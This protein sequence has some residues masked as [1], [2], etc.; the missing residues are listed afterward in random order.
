[1]PEIIA[2]RANLNSIEPTFENRI[3]SIES[4]LNKGFKVEVDVRFH[5]D[6]VY[7]GHDAAQE[8][9]PANFYGEQDIYFHCKDMQSLLT[10]QR[11]Y[12]G[13]NFFTHDNDEA[14]I[15]SRGML[16]IHPE[17][18]PGLYQDHTDFDFSR[19]IAVLPERKGI[20][21]NDAHLRFLGKFYGI[22]TDYPMRYKE[23]FDNV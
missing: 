4:A 2:H 7:L 14:T 13:S 15:T 23:E 3:K 8:I 5:L 12:R 9:L 21:Y 6:R 22:C 18:L 17:T 20:L 11:Y 19:A 16:W 1:M 10:F